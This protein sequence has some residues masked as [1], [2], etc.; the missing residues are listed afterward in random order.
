MYTLKILAAVRD[1]FMNAWED[2]AWVALSKIALDVGVC[3][4]LLLVI[5]L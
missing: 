3:A 1:D 5:V 4:F 2:R